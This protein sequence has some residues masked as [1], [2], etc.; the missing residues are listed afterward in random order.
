MEDSSLPVKDSQ[1]S[2]LRHA[3]GV[4]GIYAPEL[5]KELSKLISFALVALQHRGQESCGIVTTDHLKNT[6]SI[7]G[8]GLVN[9]VFN[10]EK[11]DRLTGFMGVG[12]TRYSTAGGKSSYLDNAQP[13][14]VSTVLGKL[15]VAQNGNLTTHKKLRTELLESG[16]AM[17]KESD[18]EVIV[19]LLSSSTGEGSPRQFSWEERISFLLK[20]A[21]GAY[22]LILMTED[23][24]YGVRDCFG[25]RPLS[26]G[27]LELIDPS[28]PSS[29]IKRYVLTSET[30]ALGLIGAS[31]LRE[32]KPG[33]IVKIDSKGIT[34]FSPY[35]PTSPSA[36]CIFEYVY[37][38]RPDSYFEGQ[39][40]NTV[41]ER[42]GRE[43]AKESPCPQ[44]DIVIGVPDSSIPAALGFSLESK[45][46]Y[47]HGLIKNRYIFRTFIQPTQQLR[48]LGVRLKFNPL[49]DTLRG[50][51]VVLVDDSIVR[52][53]T[54]V[55][56][57]NLLRS[58]GAKEVHVRVS[59]PPIRFPCFMGVDIP[60]TSHLVAFEKSI[61]EVRKLIGVDSLAYLS[62]EGMSKAV[63]EGTKDEGRE[64]EKIERAYCGA[65]FTG[66]YPLPVDDW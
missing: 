38:A 22:S 25:I 30:C 11:L 29:K 48:Q 31:F 41:R 12:H 1:E 34:S 56:L 52:G 58:S 39:L 63:K 66:K 3:C 13:V 27:V 8:V 55:N 33:E 32:V 9:Q 51:R 45:I 65:C 2:G 59:S 53:N 19:Q 47:A 23:S 17:F 6:H 14:T 16:Y 62:F 26:I 61:E 50:R 57:V 4:F 43:L 42:L 24:L 60:D 15:T 36:F 46:P 44:G 37:F 64:G 10:E 54:I 7:K 49:E 20:K 5:G 21:E 18:I 28:S 40:V 35:A